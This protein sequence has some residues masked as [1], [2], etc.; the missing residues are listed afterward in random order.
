MYVR[1]C[2][3][4][5][6]PEESVRSLDARVTGFLWILNVANGNWTPGLMIEQQSLKPVS[7]LSSPTSLHFNAGTQD[8]EIT[9][10][11]APNSGWSD[12]DFTKTSPF[13]SSGD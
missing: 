6:E 11:R 5:G 8:C 10:K 12:E 9:Q 3:R 13:T 4:G 7:H 2:A 1:S